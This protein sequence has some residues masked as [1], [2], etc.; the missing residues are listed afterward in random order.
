MVY[1]QLKEKTGSV[2][3]IISPLALMDDQ[4][5]KFTTTELI[6][7]ARVGQ[8][9][10]TDRQIIDGKFGIPIKIKYRKM[11]STDNYVVAIV[12]DEAHC[13]RHC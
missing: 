5:H 13:V 7:C 2:T 4:I 11:L 8:S 6:T 3:I 10:D 1:D 9:A 12:I